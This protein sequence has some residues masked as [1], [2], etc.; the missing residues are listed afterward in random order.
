ME[1]IAQA[2]AEGARENVRSITGEYSSSV[3]IEEYGKGR[4][5]GWRVIIRTPYA[6]LLEFGGRYM[7]AQY[8]LRNAVEALGLKFKSRKG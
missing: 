7:K 2:V 4:P 1:E 5:T 3:S 8:P 6:S